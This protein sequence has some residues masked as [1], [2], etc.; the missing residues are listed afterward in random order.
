MS[1]LI[2][3]GSGI[4]ASGRAFLPQ[5]REQTLVAAASTLDCRQNLLDSHQS[6]A[7]AAPM[8][9]IRRIGLP[10]FAACGSEKIP[11]GV[12]IQRVRGVHLI[13]EIA[14][15]GPHAA[16]TARFVFQVLL[17]RGCRLQK[18]ASPSRADT[19]SSEANAHF[20]AVPSL[21]PVPF[22]QLTIFI[23]YLISFS[24]MF[25]SYGL[26]S[27]GKIRFVRDA[28]FTRFETGSPSQVQ[29]PRLVID[30]DFVRWR[31]T[32]STSISTPS[33]GKTDGS[34]GTNSGRPQ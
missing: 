33:P 27:R 10:C 28:R 21:F 32:C 19:F 24:L 8:R 14:G 7:V 16:R 4:A 17:V 15:I 5:Q 18:V 2:F 29:F 34:N 3:S 6:P 23:D 31:H 22:G 11:S 1:G 20:I 26:L 12:P 25:C 9:V 30:C 13:F